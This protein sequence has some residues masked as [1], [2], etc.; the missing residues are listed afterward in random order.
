MHELVWRI[1]SARQ[2]VAKGMPDMVRTPVAGPEIS[3]SH[4][5]NC[6]LASVPKVI[7]LG[8]KQSDLCRSG[9]TML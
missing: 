4:R 1:K 6:L 3:L 7:R 2:C 9:S 5:N 8:E